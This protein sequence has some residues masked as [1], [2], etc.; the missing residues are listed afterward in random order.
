MYPK[1][2][3]ERADTTPDENFYSVPRFVNHID[4]KTIEAITS[5][6]EDHLVPE[7][8][9]VDLMSSWVSHLPASIKLKFFN[10]FVA[11]AI[12]SLTEEEWFFSIPSSL[13]DLTQLL[14]T[15]IGVSNL[16]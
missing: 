9:V 2:F 10:S 12:I 8:A 7:T 4:D 5:F 1:Q 14:N 13:P 11:N 15:F 16:N 3:F 6:Y